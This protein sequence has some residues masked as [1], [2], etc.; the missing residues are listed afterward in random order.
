[1]MQEV[2]IRNNGRP[3]GPEDWKRIK[4]IAEGNPNSDSCGTISIFC[5]HQSVTVNLKV[6]VGMFGVG[7]YSVF[8]VTE[9]PIVRSGDDCLIFHWKGDML[10]TTKAKVKQESN[11]TNDVGSSASQNKDWV[12]FVLAARE[13]MPY[14]LDNV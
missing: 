5:I 12:S 6:Y 3:F 10:V 8:A 2:E 14:G 4:S 7:F 13:E 9:E 11:E 1:M